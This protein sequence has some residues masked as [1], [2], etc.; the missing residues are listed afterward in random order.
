MLWKPDL[1]VRRICVERGLA[2]HG[3]AHHVVLQFLDARL[4]GLDLGGEVL[5]QVALLV[6]HVAADCAAGEPA[7]DRADHRALGAVLVVGHRTDH[8]AADGANDRALLAVPHVAHRL[9]RGAAGE[10]EARDEN[11]G[12]FH[13]RSFIR[14]EVHPSFMR[15]VA[16]R[17]GAAENF[18]GDQPADFVSPAR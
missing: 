6:V 15:T 12:V 1:I 5:F 9:V 16:S 18:L 17:I 7:A 10:R 3:D 11:G 8:G 14:R 4:A 13:E 2:G